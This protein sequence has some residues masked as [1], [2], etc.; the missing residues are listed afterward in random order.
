MNKIVL[1]KFNVIVET[2]RS[3]KKEKYFKLCNIEVLDNGQQNINGLSVEKL[4]EFLHLIESKQIEC[5]E[6]KYGKYPKYKVFVDQFFENFKRP[7][8]QNEIGYNNNYKNDF[9]VPF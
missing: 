5:N 1:K 4:K 2:T 6:T 3:D 8:E 7:M 9:E